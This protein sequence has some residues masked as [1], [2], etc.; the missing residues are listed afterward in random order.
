[1][2]SPPP[3]RNHLKSAVTWN[4]LY[5]SQ[6]CNSSSK[7]LWWPGLGRGAKNPCDTSPTY[8]NT[9]LQSLSAWYYRHPWGLGW[10]QLSAWF[11]FSVWAYF[12]SLRMCASG[13]MA[14]LMFNTG[15]ATLTQQVIRDL[16]GLILRTSCARSHNNPRRSWARVRGKGQAGLEFN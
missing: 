5:A 8:V 12:S 16:P 15:R 1:M 14:N 10:V 6:N 11:L 4:F 13:A 2:H 7:A 3:K 9:K